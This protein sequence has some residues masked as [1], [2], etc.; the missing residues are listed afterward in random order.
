LGLIQRRIKYDWN[1]AIDRI[2]SIK[3]TKVKYQKN[4]KIDW[5]EYFEDI[6]GVTKPMDAEPEKVVLNFTGRTGKIYGNK[7]NSW[8]PKIKMD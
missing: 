1:M 7:T 6:V 8:F 2:I 3:E 4:N 5:Q